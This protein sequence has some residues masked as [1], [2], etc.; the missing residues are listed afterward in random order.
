MWDRRRT[1]AKIVAISRLGER[2]KRSLLAELEDANLEDRALALT[3]AAD[4]LVAWWVARR[5]LTWDEEEHLRNP[6]VNCTESA[7]SQ[8]LAHEA[9]RL[10]RMGW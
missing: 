2:E 7:S 5:P 10:V 1:R 9:A 4:A 8:L 3:S 6:E